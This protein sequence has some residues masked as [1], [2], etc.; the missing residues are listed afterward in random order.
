MLK[1]KTIRA[2]CISTGLLS[3]SLSTAPATAAGLADLFIGA[4]VEAGCSQYVS[5]YGAPVP[6]QYYLP[7]NCCASP[8]VIIL[9][10]IDGG[11]R[12][13]RDYEEI[14]KGLAAKGYAAFIVH[15]FN[16]APQFPRPNPDV[17]AKPD[18]A[19]FKAW[20]DTVKAGVDYVQA[21]PGVDARRVGIMGLSLGGYIGSSAA[22]NNPKVKSLVVLSGGLHDTWAAKTRWLPPTL[23]IHGDQDRDVPVTE[24]AKLDHILSSKHLWHRVVILPCEGH[25]PYQRYKSQ[26]AEEVLAYFDQ[27]L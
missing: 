18:D 11:T 7:K 26:A 4:N 13:Q 14:G 16:G 17:A 21:F 3:F 15:Y 20:V 5:P 25:L 24:C 12:Y 27:T 9:H 10:G 19:S 2:L 22:A 23:A 6:V 1:H 8:A